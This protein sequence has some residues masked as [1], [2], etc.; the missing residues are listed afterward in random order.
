MRENVLIALKVAAIAA[1]LGTAVWTDV[2]VQMAFTENTR[3]GIYASASM[4]KE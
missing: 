4:T 3:A 1:V 2:T